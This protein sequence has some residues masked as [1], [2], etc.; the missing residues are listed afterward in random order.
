MR[1]RAVLQ[2]ITIMSS[3]P[4]W[5][6]CGRAPS[7]RLCA[8]RCAAA[9]LRAHAG[10]P[11]RTRAHMQQHRHRAE[12]ITIVCSRYNE[13]VLFGRRNLVA[14]AAQTRARPRRKSE[15]TRAHAVAY[16]HA[17]TVAQPCISALALA[18]PGARVRIMQ[19]RRHRVEKHHDRVLQRRFG[20]TNLVANAARGL[21]EE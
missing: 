17:H 6:T 8:R 2:N 3:L 7:R 1:A 15:R 13:T 16:L 20:R 9:P 14:N 18:F 11:S 5:R 21:R 19:Q 10:V 12:N 4:N